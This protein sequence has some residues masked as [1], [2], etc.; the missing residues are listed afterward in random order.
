MLYMASMIAA[1][2]L[3]P[4]EKSGSFSRDDIIFAGTCLLC[5]LSSSH[6]FYTFIPAD[7]QL[8]YM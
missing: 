6:G 4:I 3:S 2:I 1:G 8:Q 7:P 5:I